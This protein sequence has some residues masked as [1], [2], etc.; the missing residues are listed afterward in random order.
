MARGMK[1]VTMPAKAAWTVTLGPLP[2]ARGARKVRRG[3]VHGTPRHPGRA[4]A[5][6]GWRKESDG[7]LV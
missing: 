2:L 4:A 1:A 7:L 6:S 5:K 3:G